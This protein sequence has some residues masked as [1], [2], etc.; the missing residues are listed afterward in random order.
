MIEDEEKGEDK[1][2]RGREGDERKTRSTRR[3]SEEEWERR[4]E[5]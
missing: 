3:E 1:R 5:G 2:R 4:G